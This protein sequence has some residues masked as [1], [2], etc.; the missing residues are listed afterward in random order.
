[1]TRGRR[2]SA[3]GCVVADGRIG[4]RQRGQG[5]VRWVPAWRFVLE[6]LGGEFLVNCC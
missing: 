3:K 1:M 4:A 6:F 5:A 2:P